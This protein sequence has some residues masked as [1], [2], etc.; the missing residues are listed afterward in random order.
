MT[1]VCVH[2]IKSIVFRNSPEHQA[3]TNSTSHPPVKKI[4]C[5]APHQLKI[6]SATLL[7][8]QSQYIIVSTQGN[9]KTCSVIW[10]ARNIQCVLHILPPV[11]G[12][13]H[14]NLK[15]YQDAGCLDVK[16][17]YLLEKVTCTNT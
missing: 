5:E 4:L 17:K 1:G 9:R 6:N 16:L 3:R 2:M 13:L 10:A 11:V 12:I 15:K 8:T 7:L 14:D